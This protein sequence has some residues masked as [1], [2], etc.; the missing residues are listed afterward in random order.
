MHTADYSTKNG[1]TTYDA[2]SSDPFADLDA[3]SASVLGI[4]AQ[5]AEGWTSDQTVLV[6]GLLRS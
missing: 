2:D 5:L 4:S 3:E 1:D 6:A